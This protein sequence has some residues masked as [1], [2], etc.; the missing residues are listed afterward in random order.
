MVSVIVPVYRAKK[1][2]ERCVGCIAAQS[3]QNIELILVDDGSDDGSGEICD[4]LADGYNKITVIHDKNGGAAHARNTG[5]A[6]ANGEWICFIDSDDIIPENMLD[7]LMK[8]ASSSAADIVV[9]AHQKCNSSD[10]KD[11]NAIKEFFS[12]NHTSPDYPSQIY[13]GHEGVKA[14]LYQRGMISAP[15][16]MISKKSL[17]NDISFPEG[18]AAED[19]GTI[20]K[21]FLKADTIAY[22]DLVL[23][24]YMQSASNTVYSTSSD[25]NPDYFLH[26]KEM[27]AFFSNNHPD[28]IKAASSRHLSACFQILSETQPEKNRSAFISEVYDSIHSVRGTVFR[29]KE[30]RSK[31]RLAA[32]GSYF[33]LPFIHRYLYKMH[34]KELPP[35]DLSCFPS[36]TMVE[37]QGRCDTEGKAVGHAPKVLAEYRNLNK[38]HFDIDVFAPETIL[39]DL[40]EDPGLKVTPLKEYIVMKSG[41][42]VYERIK[43]KFKMFS[44]I[45]YTLKHS[46]ADILWFFNVEF[47]LFLYLA[48]FG[49]RD[50]KIVVTLFKN[51][52]GGGR[53][54]K[55]KQKIFELG[56]KRVRA[57]IS[58]GPLFSFK[59]M[60]SIFI[61]D[62]IYDKD[63]YEPYRTMEKKPMAVCLGTMGVD[64]QLEQIV[65]SFSVLTYPLLVAGRFY[66][67]ERFERLKEVATPNV[68]VFDT[69]LTDEEYL[70]LLGQ[71]TYAILPYNEKNYSAQTS[72]VMQEAVFTDTIVFTHK[73]ILKGNAIPGV[74][75]STYY[76]ISDA[77]FTGESCIMR[78]RNILKEY[79]RL[80]NDVYDRSN[81]TES[82]K[83]FFRSLDH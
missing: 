19:M 25:R 6:K 74:G 15:W 83:K 54:A 48:I 12:A 8:N 29:D 9:C 20:Y 21:L 46:K 80:R 38:K 52:Y 39:R 82:Y 79:E 63:K 31:N 55:I 28:C 47:Y 27:L 66:D 22:T 76:G 75:Y 41:D 56:Q 30:A 2:I 61:P 7:E 17:W 43:N 57:C 51:S 77:V 14:L 32:L 44:N 18:T 65:N 4:W 68:K 62:Y 53:L 26:S 33:S 45:R 10:I 58:A 35:S 71:A 72:G 78:N 59:N 60:S 42:T 49:A 70:T 81:I 50:R 5:L 64:K 11:L 24:G 34:L 40:P 16:G 23:Y 1:T 67:K 13:K 36:I 37:Y 69:Y 3:Y 73:D